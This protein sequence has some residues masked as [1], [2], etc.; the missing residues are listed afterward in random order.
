MLSNIKVSHWVRSL[1]VVSSLDAADLIDVC[2]VSKAC[3]VFGSDLLED[4]Q[5]YSE[6]PLCLSG[7]IGV[8]AQT[9]A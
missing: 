7:E 6:M 1:L 8:F 3:S 2:G 9:K 5:L 4:M